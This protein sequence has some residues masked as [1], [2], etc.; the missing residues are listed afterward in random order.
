[1][2]DNK[3]KADD[4]ALIVCGTLLF[5]LFIGEPDLYDLIYKVLQRMAEATP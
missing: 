3:S 1:M 4:V 2:S 5:L